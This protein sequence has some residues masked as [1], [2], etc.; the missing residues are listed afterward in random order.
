[1]LVHATSVLRSASKTGPR[2]SEHLHDKASADEMSLD[3]IDTASRVWDRMLRTSREVL[4][5]DIEK[6]VNVV[7]LG[8]GKISAASAS[9]RPVID[10]PSSPIAQPPAEDPS[11]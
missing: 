10:V 6:T 9:V 5:L 11:I 1:M 7:V 8:S 3:Q 2:L 4:N